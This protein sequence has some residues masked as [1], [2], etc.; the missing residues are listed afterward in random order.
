MSA[1]RWLGIPY[2]L[3]VCCGA[4]GGQEVA[5]GSAA[6]GT[7]LFVDSRPIG[8]TVSV[9]GQV[10]EGTTPLLVRGLPPGKYTVSFSK[11]GVAD[12]TVDTVITEAEASTVFAELEMQG[13]IIAIPGGLILGSDDEPLSEG[14]YSIPPGR[15]V[16][17]NQNNYGTMKPVYSHQRWID[18][19]NIAIPITTGFAIG[20]TVAEATNPRTNYQLSPFT[21]AV[22]AVDALLIGA[23]IGFHVHRKG[24]MERWEA[25]QAEADPEGAEDLFREAERALERGEWSRSL[26]LDDRLLQN[27]PRSDP[28]PESLYRSGRVQYLLQNREDAERRFLILIND[29][30][31]A[32]LWD[33]TQRLLAEISFKR[34]DWEKGL[35]ALDEIA[36]IDPSVDPES[37]AHR[38]A[39]ALTSWWET[40]PGQRD[41]A[42]RAWDRLLKGWPDSPLIDVYRDARE[43]VMSPDKTAP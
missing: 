21:I 33:R 5:D 31:R 1:F 39:A 28:V 17:G 30:P 24:W 4:I 6:G 37:V 27:H 13:A 10:Q 32:Y 26:E 12:R 36:Y 3:L 8:A 42:L 19:L 34:E 23:N 35:T 41:A 43:S 22:I 11:P 29:F 14:G 38:R 16:V 20:L 9:D 7:K 15:Y 18:A 25:V 2:L 40:D